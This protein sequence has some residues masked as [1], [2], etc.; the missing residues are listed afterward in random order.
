[1]PKRLRILGLLSLILL[2]PGIGAA[3]DFTA[4][5]DYG[6]LDAPQPTAAGDKVE[7][8]EFFSYG[9]PHCSNLEPHIVEWAAS[10]AADDVELVRVAVAWNSGM[11]SLSRVYYA[12]EMAGGTEEADAAVFKLLHVDK[13]AE[14]TLDTIADVL[15]SHGV[16]RDAFIQS[17]QSAEV[18]ERVNKAKE[19]TKRYRISGVPT[20][21]IDG[22]YT[23][24]IPH[25]NDFERMFE[26]TD[27]LVGQSAE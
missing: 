10:P 27:H 4:G 11:E 5:E 8:I 16:D 15:A 12:A 18:T 22:R 1:M 21:V 6:E 7:V 3:Q 23:V 14:L 17:F 19:M 26:V 24:G 20:L 9:C 13:P 2:V 25:G